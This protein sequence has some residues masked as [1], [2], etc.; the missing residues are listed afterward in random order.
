MVYKTQL[1][2]GLLVC[3]FLLLPRAVLS[4]RRAAVVTGLACSVLVTFKSTHF[5]LGLYAVRQFS[6]PSVIKI[7]TQTIIC[8]IY[9]FA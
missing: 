5:T 6:C 8:L 7:T 1:G 4:Q 2:N 3:E 9:A